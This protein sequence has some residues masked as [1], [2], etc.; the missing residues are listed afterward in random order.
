MNNGKDRENKKEKVE[1]EKKK[2]RGG[3][4]PMTLEPSTFTSH[5]LPEEPV[6]MYVCMYVCMR[7]GGAT[8]ASISHSI[9]IN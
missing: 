4:C 7:I 5:T 6:C 1:K 2:K 9:F 8:L 3:D